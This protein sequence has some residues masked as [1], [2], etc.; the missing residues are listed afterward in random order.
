MNEKD[1]DLLINKI[2]RMK[3]AIG[4][5]NGSIKGRV[6]RKYT[7]YRNYYTTSNRDLLLDELVEEGYMNVRDD[8]INK[9]GYVYWVT[10]KGIEFISRIT[11]VE[12]LKEADK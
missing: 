10:D 11:G 12:I 8:N 1:T 2:D 6:H 9:K 3:H 4:F 5:K 7:M